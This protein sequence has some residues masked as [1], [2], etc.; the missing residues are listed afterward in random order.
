MREWSPS[1]STDFQGQPLAK[2]TDMTKEQRDRLKARRDEER[3][4]RAK[5]WYWFTSKQL[6]TT[7]PGQLERLLGL[8]ADAR[9]IEN[10]R[11]GKNCPSAPLVER[12]EAMAPGGHRI[13][14]S[15]PGRLF[16]ALYGTEQHCW[17]VATV[18]DEQG[19]DEWIGRAIG[20]DESVSR[21]TQRLATDIEQ[22]EDPDI[23]QVAQLA[24]LLHLQSESRF[25]VHPWHPEGGFE[26]LCHLLMTNGQAAR[27]LEHLHIRQDV[28]AWAKGKQTQRIK[29]DDNLRIGFSASGVPHIGLAV[30]LHLD[31]PLLFAAGF[32]PLR[33][34]HRYLHLMPNTLARAL[35]NL[36]AV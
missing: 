2:A 16:A 7:S 6:G 22:G 23:Q 25:V 4:V 34:R 14:T 13:I 35:E 36:P 10:Q 12:A 9:T 21:F 8:P 20:I 26:L 3:A 31:Q 18:L 11:D 33:D 15:G 30:Q 5:A 28:L 27:L 32:E 17:R 19:R 24:A 29:T 1:F